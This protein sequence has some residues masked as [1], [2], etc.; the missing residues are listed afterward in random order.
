MLAF[1]ELLLAIIIVAVGHCLKNKKIS[2][3]KIKRMLL[4]V[5]ATVLAILLTIIVLQQELIQHLLD[6][7]SSQ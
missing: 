1:F 7:I 5:A 4:K 2:W 6:K 3:V